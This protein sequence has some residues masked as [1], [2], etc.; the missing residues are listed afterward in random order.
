M[1]LNPITTW[2]LLNGGASR[3]EIAEYAGIELAVCDAI[4]QRAI[5]KYAAAL[6]LPARAA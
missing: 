4:C 6:V 2:N 5:A 3:S 1:T